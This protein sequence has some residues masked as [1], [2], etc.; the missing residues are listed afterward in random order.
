MKAG[1][2]FHSAPQGVAVTSW[3]AAAHE[4]AG[5]WIDVNALATTHAGGPVAEF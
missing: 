2:D 3:I 1:V 5:V 4:G